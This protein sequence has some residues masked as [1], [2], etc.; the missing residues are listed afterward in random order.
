MKFLGKANVVK[1]NNGDSA[2]ENSRH[3]QGFGK[4]VTMEVGS[5]SDRVRV[6]VAHNGQILVEKGKEVKP[7][8]AISISTN[9]GRS[10]GNPGD[11]T[12]VEFSF[13]A[14]DDAKGNDIFKPRVPTPEDIPLL[15]K[16]GLI[17]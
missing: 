17:K 4:F 16:L 2:G 7:G 13:Y 8:Q 10:I 3:S 1:I 6:T 15:K 12:H 5:D 11:H 9:S 14:G